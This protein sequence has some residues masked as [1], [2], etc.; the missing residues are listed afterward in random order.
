M[1]RPPERGLT[2]ADAT[3]FEAIAGHGLRGAV[4]GRTILSGNGKLMRDHGVGLR[5][6][7]ARGEALQGTG[8]TI[9]YTAVEGGRQGLPP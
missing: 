6:L 7:E 8:R 4:N 2:L 1:D 5:A 9:V 3:H